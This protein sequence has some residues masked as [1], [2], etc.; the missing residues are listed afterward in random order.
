MFKHEDVNRFYIF[1]EVDEVG[2]GE[3]GLSHSDSP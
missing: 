2:G 3:R 1:A